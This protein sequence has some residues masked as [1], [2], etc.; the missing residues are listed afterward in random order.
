MKWINVVLLI[1][2]VAF[3]VFSIVGP[4][5]FGLSK[6]FFR[7]CK[8][9]LSVFIVINCFVLAYREKRKMRQDETGDGTVS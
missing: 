3:L 4:D 9:V 1:I 2:V 5:K 8:L 6:D 7:I